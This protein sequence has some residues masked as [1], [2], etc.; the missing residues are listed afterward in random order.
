MYELPK[1]AKLRNLR[2]RK[3][4]EKVGFDGKQPDGNRKE[5]F[6]YLRRE[7]N[8]GKSTV[9]RPIEKSIL[10]NIS[11]IKSNLCKCKQLRI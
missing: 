6:W 1:D 10:L 8:C 11:S 9:K 5:N 2:I 3:F 4:Q 7:E